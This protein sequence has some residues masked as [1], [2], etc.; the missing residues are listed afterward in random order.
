MSINISELLVEK[1]KA[2]PN[3]SDYIEELERLLEVSNEATHNIENMVHQS[4]TKIQIR[5]NQYDNKFVK[6]IELF[7]GGLQ[8]YKD[9]QSERDIDQ[10][11]RLAEEC[12]ETLHRVD[13]DQESKLEEDI[14]TS[15]SSNNDSI[16]ACQEC[17]E[18]NRFDF[19]LE[20][21]SLFETSKKSRLNLAIFLSAYTCVKYQRDDAYWGSNDDINIMN[22]ACLLAS[23]LLGYDVAEE[24]SWVQYTGRA[25]ADEIAKFTINKLIEELPELVTEHNKLYAFAFEAGDIESTLANLIS[26]KDDDCFKLATEQNTNIDSGW[27]EEEV[28]V[29]N[30]LALFQSVDNYSRSQNTLI[31]IR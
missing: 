9:V 17:Y 23:S 21:K 29:I 3:D 18:T 24:E 20:D 5:N 31:R 30:K 27:S 19:L 25:T 10:A 13:L 16:S 1:R 15:V 12:G 2:L 7:I 11:Q 28:D 22:F 6:Q 26:T 8:L 4:L 14:E